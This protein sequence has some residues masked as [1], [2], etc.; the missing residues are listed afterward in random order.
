MCTGTLRVH[1]F[2][3]S[4][5]L[6]LLCTWHPDI[7]LWLAGAYSLEGR[8]TVGVEQTNANYKLTRRWRKHVES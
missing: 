8:H 1:S 7:W 2:I 6:Y 5:I 3:H 4:L